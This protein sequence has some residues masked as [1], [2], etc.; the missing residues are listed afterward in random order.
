MGSLRDKLFCGDNGVFNTVGKHEEFAMT[1]E[2][3]SEYL[4]RRAN[5][6]RNALVLLVMGGCT[7]G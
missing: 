2:Q 3:R 5:R 6:Y 1:I 4:E 7:V